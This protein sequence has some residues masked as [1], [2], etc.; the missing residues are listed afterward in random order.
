VVAGRH[1]FRF[2]GESRACEHALCAKPDESM[3]TTFRRMYD[4][5]ERDRELIDPSRYCEVRFEELVAEPIGQIQAVYDR[6]GLAPPR[7]LCQIS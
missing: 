2:G 1:R 4:A 7:V 3:F 5:F 6:L